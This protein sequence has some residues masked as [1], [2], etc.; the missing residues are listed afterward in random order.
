M[1]VINYSERCRAR[2]DYDNDT[3]VV[4]DVCVNQIGSNQMIRGVLTWK[5]DD[6]VSKAFLTCD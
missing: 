2:I 6:D 1:S 5:L 4:R 3:C